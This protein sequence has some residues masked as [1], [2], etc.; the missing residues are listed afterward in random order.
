MRN[1]FHRDQGLRLDHIL[2][3]P[4]LSP[5]LEAAGVDR[6]VRGQAGASDHAPVWITLKR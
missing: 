2:L 3:S 6:D 4:T 1:R 5:W